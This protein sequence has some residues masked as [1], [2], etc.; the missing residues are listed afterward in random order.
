M[1]RMSPGLFQM[2]ASLKYIITNTTT[3]NDIISAYII[4]GKTPTGNIQGIGKVSH[5]QY[6]IEIT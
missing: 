4:K 2:P 1:L 6:N 3:I 5:D